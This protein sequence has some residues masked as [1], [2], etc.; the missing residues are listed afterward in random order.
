MGAK[1]KYDNFLNSFYWNSRFHFE[2]FENNFITDLYSYVNL[3]MAMIHDMI[4]LCLTKPQ[5]S[6]NRSHWSRRPTDSAEQLGS[7]QGRRLERYV[8]ALWE[9][10]GKFVAVGFLGELLK[11]STSQCHVFIYIINL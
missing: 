10:E 3:V 5:I 2:L 7:P 1:D 8:E 6:N 4:L 9:K 11:C